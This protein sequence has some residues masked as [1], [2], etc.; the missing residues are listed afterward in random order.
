VVLIDDEPAVRGTVSTVLRPHGWKVLEA[1][2]GEAGLR[3]VREHRPEVVICDLLMPRQNGFQVIRSIRD[4]P[5]LRHVRILVTSGRDYASDRIN[6]FRSGADDYLLKPMD[7]TELLSTLERLTSAEAAGNPPAAPRAH[8]PGVFHGKPGVPPPVAV[9]PADQPARLRFWGVRGSIPTPGPATV[10]YGGNTSCVEV[11]ADGEIIILD[12]G[13]GIRSLGL[14]LASEFP[15][16]A[17]RIT[18]LITHTHWDHIQ[19]FPFFLPA[20]DPKN[21]LRV[22]GY[23]GS[24]QGLESVLSGQMESPYFPIGMKQ[25]PGNIEVEELKGLKF[26]V[27]QVQVEAA[28]VNHPGICVGYRLNTSTGSVVYIPDNE[29][30]QRLRAL[31]KERSPSPA[32]SLAYASAQDERMVNFIRG[33]DVLIIDSQYDDAEY[34]RHVGWGHG[35]VDDV[36]ALALMAQVR[37][38]FLFHHDPE[39]DDERVGRMVEWARAMVACQQESLAVEAAREGLEFVLRGSPVAKA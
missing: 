19:G 39:H 37:Q 24:R 36:V 35:C 11:R 17:L 6:A 2:D 32:E 4:S 3:L 25:M 12:S 1:E 16:Q 8:P 5:D 18:L 30:Y 22:L 13:T 9:L 10:H 7:A 27:G 38:L 14:E 21:H 31:P 28:F 20:Y 29:P 23:E 26:E 34:Q 33:A 15:D